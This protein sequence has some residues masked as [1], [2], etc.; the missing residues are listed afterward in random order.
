MAI[1]TFLGQF[2]VILG[3]KC[4]CFFTDLR[5]IYGD[6]F[7]LF[8]KFEYWLRSDPPKIGQSR[9]I[10][11]F[12]LFPQNCQPLNLIKSHLLSR[13][14]EMNT[15]G[16]FYH[17]FEIKY[18]PCCG[19]LKI[20]RRRKM[21][22][23]DIAPPKLPPVGWTWLSPIYFFTDL[24][25]T[26]TSEDDF[27]TFLKFWVRALWKL[28][29]AEKCIFDIVSSKLPAVAFSQT[30]DELLG[31]ILSLF[32]NFEYWP[33]SGPLKIGQS[34]KK[35]FW[36]QSA[37]NIAGRWLDLIKSYLLFQR[38]QMNTWGRFCHFLE[39]FCYIGSRRNAIT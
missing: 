25:W 4:N 6:D 18:W 36:R 9:K 10:A 3:L 30:S 38:P 11:F 14:P 1:R 34:R 24:G 26:W 28:T 20:G 37:P 21:R 19:P 5:W 13:R 12:S 2:E 31:K 29:K 16:K 39:S 35:R 15:G 22:F 17:F 7:S 23:G 33:R 8:W 27:I 32:W